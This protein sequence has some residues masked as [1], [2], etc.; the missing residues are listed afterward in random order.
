MANTYQ[1]I[2]STP[3]SGT[4]SVVIGSIPQT[5]DDLI[6]KIS[7]NCSYTGAGVIN[8]Y[9]D[10]NSSN[11]TAYSAKIMY[12]Y[13]S[14]SSNVD[15]TTMTTGTN[16]GITGGQMAYHINTSQ[17][18]SV[19]VFSCGEI[20]IGNY[21]NATGFAK[22][23]LSDMAVGQFSTSN[24]SSHTSGTMVGRINS[25]SAISS[26]RLVQENAGGNTFNTGTV[27]S[28]YGIKRT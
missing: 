18:D 7:A 26:I 4:T 14:T 25:G 11:S 2:S 21:C 1:L 8:L 10:F 24:N 27:F 28:L 13:G 5:F 12:A 3:T 16:Y 9:L 6:L 17:T 15:T 22:T 19:N 20:Y 23:Y